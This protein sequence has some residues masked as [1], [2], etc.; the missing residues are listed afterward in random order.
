MSHDVMVLDA[1]EQVITSAEADVMLRRTGKRQK[2][3]LFDQAASIWK[4]SRVITK[5]KRWPMS[6]GWF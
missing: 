3:P 2:C 5:L 4:T 1:R 6:R